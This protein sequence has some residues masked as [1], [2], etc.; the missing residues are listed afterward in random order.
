[1]YK[2]SWSLDVWCWLV[3]LLLL[4][5]IVKRPVN[6]WDSVLN[7][8]F[9]RQALIVCRNTV[10]RAQLLAPCQPQQTTEPV[11][12][13][14][15]WNNTSQ[16]WFR[17]PR[18][19]GK[20]TEPGSTATREESNNTIHLSGNQIRSDQMTSSVQSHDVP[21][22]TSI[23]TRP[24]MFIANHRFVVLFPCFKSELKWQLSVLA[25]ISSLQKNV[26]GSFYVTRVWFL[27]RDIGPDLCFFM[28]Q[29]PQTKLNWVSLALRKGR[30]VHTRKH[31]FPPNCR[32][33]PAFTVASQ[34][35]TQPPNKYFQGL[36]YDSLFRCF[37]YICIQI[38]GVLLAC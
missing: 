18:S 28:L 5:F 32:P 35:I 6:N 38:Q 17:S 37:S 12:L 14:S 31:F 11:C 26:C 13:S 9:Y 36:N 4:T 30:K 29:A 33:I 21:I 22:A 7:T 16:M 27:E 10:I 8:I 1:M 3:W 15:Q 24:E 34:I 19:E 20:E 23:Y 25:F 2:P